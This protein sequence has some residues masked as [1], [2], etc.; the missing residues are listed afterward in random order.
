MTVREIDEAA[1]I[2]EAL[3]PVLGNMGYGVQS[4]DINSFARHFH[5]ELPAVELAPQITL[6]ILEL[7]DMPESR[8]TGETLC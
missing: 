2:V 7:A 5:D 6:K 4:I 8:V 3:R 1:K